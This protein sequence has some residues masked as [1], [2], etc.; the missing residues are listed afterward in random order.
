MPLATLAQSIPEE[1]IIPG[2]VAELPKMNE[3]GETAK[4]YKPEDTLFK[5]L[6]QSPGL[7]VS[8]A[9]LS[10]VMNETELIAE[11]S[12]GAAVITLGT[13][14][15]ISGANLA[16]P[17]G[18]DVTLVGN[19]ILSR[20]NTIESGSFITVEAGA[21]LTINGVRIEAPSGATNL[22]GILVSDN[23]RL[24]L[25]DG[26]VSGF[27]T[28]GDSGGGVYIMNGTFEM[29][30]GEISGNTANTGGGVLAAPGNFEM[31]GG[32]ISGNTADTGGGVFFTDI[33]SFSMSGGEISGNIATSH[34]GGVYLVHATFDMWNGKINNNTVVDSY[35]GGII[36]DAD[37][38]LNMHGG[39]FSGNFAPLG[40]GIATHGGQF[41][42]YDGK[43]TNN[44]AAFG[45][46][47]YDEFFSSFPFIS[48]VYSGEIS[49]NMAEQGGGIYVEQDAFFTVNDT[50]ISGNTAEQGGGI[51]VA[52]NAALNITGLSSIIDNHAQDGEGSGGGIYTMDYNNLTTASTV[53][54]S[55]NS[56]L[57][58]YQPPE[59]ADEDYPNIQYASS[60]I[61]MSGIYL[62]PINNFDINYAGETPIS[63]LPS[64]SPSPAPSPP[65]PSPPPSL[66]SPQPPSQ[67]SS[68]YTSPP[69]SS[70]SSQQSPPPS[71]TP[72]PPPY[73]QPLPPPLPLPQDDVP[74]RHAYLI[75][76]EGHIRPNA[77]IARAEVATI[78]FR[79]ISDDLRTANWSQSNPYPDI[80]I[81]N[82]FNNA[83]STTTQLGIFMGRPDGTF[84]PNQPITRAELVAAVVRF[85]NTADVS[86]VG[87]DLFS[88]IR[89]HWASAYIN[90]AAMYNW[91]QGPQGL[92]GVFNP[93]RPIT[94]AE[95]A[96]II[97]RIFNRLP[98]SAADMLPDMQTWP[99]NTNTDVWYYLY[100][101][102]AS[103]SY[104][105]EMDPD[106]IH[107]R[108]IALIPVRNWA[109]LER[110]DSTPTGF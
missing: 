102:A 65:A 103:N 86:Y 72:S 58:A 64:P 34:G 10:V 95:T 42:M 69:P 17:A 77:D 41:T 50:K 5:Y 105:F 84:K 19:F 27:V 15:N 71:S 56:A 29:Y 106:D 6:E 31:Y 24:M 57:S 25:N 83:V 53:V 94:R 51:Y 96:A 98:Q 33:G 39:E 40:G 108:W 85:M 12:A 60:S 87:E 55:Q 18:A 43:I 8:P 76:S 11:I 20:A 80:T 75:G 26:S 54:L 63:P 93:D 45:G 47:I 61:W 16:I 81:E 1:S 92:G 78:L 46:G 82:W 38:I 68:P 44:T 109:A 79:L 9:S 3:N 66:P 32:V 62:N 2:D 91:V 30:G 21:S 49:G 74:Y 100:I 90:T 35:G 4:G 13:N 89:G 70:P 97:N 110:P 23:A 59:N 73:L 28:Y 48:A 99:D 7:S 67:P 22:R 104:T 88:D 36:L 101:Q 52:D 37:G 107:E 14:I